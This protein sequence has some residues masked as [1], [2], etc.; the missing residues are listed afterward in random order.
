MIIYD[1]LKRDFLKDVENDAIA[2]IVRQTILEKMG[3]HPSDS[4]DNAWNNSMNYMYKLLTDE[5]IP[6][7]AGVAIEYNIPQTAKRVDFMISGYDNRVTADGGRTACRTDTTALRGIRSGKRTARDIYCT[8]GINPY[9][10]HIIA[11]RCMG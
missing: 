1:G 2:I 10:V 4:E 11:I 6:S 9:D 8:T 3:R 5:E 7:D